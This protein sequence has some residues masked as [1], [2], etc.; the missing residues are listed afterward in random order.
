MDVNKSLHTDL[1]TQKRIC[2]CQG[3]TNHQIVSM[4][5]QE[6][7]RLQQ[8]ISQKAVELNRLRDELQQVHKRR[9][10]SSED[11]R[12]LYDENSQLK[13]MV[14]LFFLVPNFRVWLSRYLSLLLLVDS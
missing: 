3:A 5:T 14:S 2:W 9:K 7:A 6:N 10:L 1:S 8:E 13:D 4:H 12:R 11:V